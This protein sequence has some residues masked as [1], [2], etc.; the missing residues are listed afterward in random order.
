MFGCIA[1]MA[2]IFWDQKPKSGPVDI[3]RVD[4]LL[5]PVERIDLYVGMVVVVVTVDSPGNK[6]LDIWSSEGTE[7]DDITSSHRNRPGCGRSGD[8][9]L[10]TIV[11]SL[12]FDLGN[13]T[14]IDAPTFACPLCSKTFLIKGAGKMLIVN[15]DFN[16]TKME[17]TFRWWKSVTT[18][19]VAGDSHKLRDGMTRMPWRSL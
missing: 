4:T 10:R 6:V 9:E 1:Y 19:L 7:G 14:I 17:T 16:S 5:V 13:D 11:L 3:I 2:L 18:H 12:R 15:E 8:S